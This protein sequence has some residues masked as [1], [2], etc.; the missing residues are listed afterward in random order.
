MAVN[1]DAE[2]DQKTDSFTAPPLPYA[3]EALAPVISADTLHYHHDKHHQTYA[4][5]LNDLIKS[6]PLKG[7]SLV[8]IVKA[9]AGDAAQA[10]IFNNSAQ[11]WN[12]TFYWHSLKPGGGG[13]PKGEI[14]DRID[15]DFGGYD[16]FR[17]A[18]KTAGLGQF[19]SGWA[20][21]V[22][23]GGKLK[24]VTT[25]NAGTPITTAQVPLFTSD[26]WEHAY[27]LDYQNRRAD[28]LDAFLDRLV[29]WE[30]AADRLKRG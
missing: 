3:Y 26:V 25:G 18:F 20:W 2:L 27:Y 8:Q 6:S 16:A 15:A 4:N 12:H 28:Y 10:K 7:K 24:I 17:T 22:T 19:G 9:S 30:F 1:V 29:N 11:V 14:A 5:T 13:K 21:L 23:E